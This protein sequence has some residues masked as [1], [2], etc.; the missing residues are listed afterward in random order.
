MKKILSILSVFSFFSF[1]VTN[2]IA[3]ENRPNIFN[4]YS[5]EEKIMSIRNIT[6]ESLKNYGVKV[7]NTL[8]NQEVDSLIE[9]LNLKEILTEDE[10]ANLSPELINMYI[11]ANSFLNDISS[12]VPGYDW[13][14]RKVAWQSQWSLRDLFEEKE[15][16]VA[17]NVSGWLDQIYLLNG[18]TLS[19][20]F[21]DEEKLGWMGQGEPAYARININKRLVANKDG[22]IIYNESNP[23][24]IR[25][26]TAT[27]LDPVFNSKRAVGPI[28]NGYASSSD[29]INLKGIY[30][31]ENNG[32]NPGFIN[33]SPSV[34]D[35]INNL[36]VNFE[37]GNDVL[38]RSKEKI[39]DR[40]DEY[41][42]NNPIYLSENLI[43]NSNIVEINT[44]FKNQIYSI[45]FSEALKRREFVDDKGEKYTKE[46]M[47]VANRF[48][49][50]LFTNLDS[51]IE[52]MSKFEWI[53]NNKENKEF[54]L[55]F[56]KQLDNSNSEGWRKKDSTEDGL[57]TDEIKDFFDKLL[58]LIEL[59]RNEND[60]LSKQLD[61]AKTL[62]VVANNKLVINS[63]DD[64]LEQKDDSN[65]SL[66]SN[67]K[68]YTDFED[69]GIDNSYKL[70]TTYYSEKV[71]KN[72]EEQKYE[73]DKNSPNNKQ[74]KTDIFFKSVFF[75]HRFSMAED[76]MISNFNQ[77]YNASLGIE[78]SSFN[79]QFINIEGVPATQENANKL[80]D[81]LLRE[82]SNLPEGTEVNS[83][84]WRIYMVIDLYIYNL[85]K[86]VQTMFS[87]PETFHQAKISLDFAK[88]TGVETNWALADDDIAFAE[89]IKNQEYN[90]FFNET[91]LKG[92]KSEFAST[93]YNEGIKAALN[94]KDFDFYLFKTTVNNYGKSLSPK[95][96]MNQDYL[97]E[98]YFFSNFKTF[99]KLADNYLNLL[100]VYW[101]KNVRNNPKNP[102]Y[103]E[104]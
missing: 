96:S 103:Y 41:L 80:L 23:D 12:K 97:K 24:A 61:F 82:Y 36:P 95:F 47:A 90:F 59:S 16:G 78:S 43:D 68:V 10:F 94:N 13:I 52:Q 51:T 3:C 66:E 25:E 72:I 49:R 45:L 70:A 54:L 5:D 81:N 32:L 17:N 89:L 27:S 73:P 71:P 21:L 14:S 20:T 42:L 31:L 35:L 8:T 15:W 79:N 48:V 2:V 64:E 19:V 62:L 50:K 38:K 46:Q 37:F 55:E 84:D 65:Q 40:L 57:S 9:K 92:E 60:P 87:T 56:T 91:S 28:Y 75:S 104:Q 86:T 69:F 39:Q 11:M 101:D 53:Q 22:D 6:S 83:E 99:T 18:W 26:A 85:T 34:M 7:G 102:D 77:F 30:S 100:E 63:N 33:Y 88:E 29:L 93:I 58:K 74:F 76:S 98:E 44:I 67:L 1:T 4:E